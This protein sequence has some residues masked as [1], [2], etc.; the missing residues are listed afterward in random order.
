[1]R[2]LRCLLGFV[3]GLLAT[4]ALF[5]RF[6]QPSDPAFEAAF[7]EASRCNVLFVG[8]SYLEVGLKTEVFDAE[9][10]ALGH[11]L[12]S[13]MFTRSALR[14]YELKHDLEQL[15]NHRWPAL[16]QVAVDMTLFPGGVGFERQNWFN[17]RTVHW[18]TWDGLTWLYRHYRAGKKSWRE[19][20]P[21]LVGHLQHVAMN[22]LGIGRGGVI[23]TRARKVERLLGWETGQEKPREVN[24]LPRFRKKVKLSDEE[25]EAATRRL[26]QEKASA[27]AR[28]PSDDDSW[29]RELEPVIRARRF[30]PVFLYSPVYVNRMPPRLTRT[31]KK[32]LVFLDFDD[33]DR[34]PELYEPDSR[35]RT[36][37][38]S[39]EGAEHYSRILAKEL[40]RLASEPESPSEPVPR[41]ER[42]K[43]RKQSKRDRPGER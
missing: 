3:L 14:S 26:A 11:P 17:P 33:P 30:E 8:P 28:R 10:R 41:D 31:G 35:G 13:C 23:L 36:A 6:V 4:A 25:A 16:R 22:Y 9:T 43:R 39:D 15:M 42:E 34:Y 5:Y 38:L 37:H 32:P 29:A 19:R 12:R 40:V 2:F 7:A 24:R 21:E 20:A 1:V 18:H 27:R